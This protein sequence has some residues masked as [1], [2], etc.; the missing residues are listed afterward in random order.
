ME[1][2]LNDRAELKKQHPCGCK[3][4][5]ITR[6]GMDIKFR[7]ELCGREIML[8]RSKAEKCIKKLLSEEKD[9]E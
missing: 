7:C 2:H 6:I 4:V 5:V 3:T 1:L 8:P 9:D